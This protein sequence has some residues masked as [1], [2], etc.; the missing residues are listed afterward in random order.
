M[1]E[2]FLG[3]IRLGVTYLEE[4][5]HDEYL[6]TLVSECVETV[7]QRGEDANENT[8]HHDA[9]EESAEHCVGANGHCIA[10]QKHAKTHEDSRSRHEDES[11][12]WLA[13]SKLEQI[14]AD[15]KKDLLHAIVSFPHIFDDWVGEP[16]YKNRPNHPTYER[17]GT[18]VSNLRRAKLP[19]RSGEDSSQNNGRANI[20][21]IQ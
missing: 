5:V 4:H 15:E 19:G 18:N 17:S 14:A 3:R 21:G 13:V 8:D 2:K 11:E 9:L 16:A 1:S 12:F 7:G 20:P 6:A 10:K